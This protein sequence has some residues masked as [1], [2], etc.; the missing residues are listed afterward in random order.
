MPIALLLSRAS[1]FQLFSSVIF[2]HLTYVLSIKQ[3]SLAFLRMPSQMV[4]FW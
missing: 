1:G 3:L 4:N 2:F